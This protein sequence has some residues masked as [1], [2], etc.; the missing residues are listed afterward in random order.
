MAEF[1]LNTELLTNME[2]Q[3]CL[4]R[5][6]STS[7]YLVKS[8]K[9]EQQYV[10]KH[11]S[12]PEHQKQVDALIFSGAAA[13]EQAAQL[14][15]QQ[16]VSDY[17][18]E[19]EQMEALASSP[20]LRCFRSYEIK[21]K[22]NA[23]GF[24]VFLLAE[25][26]QTLDGYLKENA[27]TQTGA[28]NLAMDLCTALTELRGAGL[29]HRDVKP[30]NIYL[31]NQGH[32]MLGDLGLANVQDLK[33][34]SIPES[35]LSS[36]SA[37]ELFDLMA[38]VN[39][40]IDIYAVGMILYRIYNSNHAP[41]EDEKTTAKAADKLRVMGQELPPPMF[42]DYEMAEIIRKACAHK[43]EDRYQDPEEM[44]QALMNYMLRNQV[45]DAPIAPPIV[46]EDPDLELLMEAEA[47]VEPVQFADTAEM[48]E[49][50]ILNMSPD[51]D[52]LND[53]IESVHRDLERDYASNYP[54]NDEI[55]DNPFTAPVRK[56]HSVSRWLP[57]VL[58][59]L[60][61]AAIAAGAYW[62]FFVR[63]D[64]ITINSMKTGEQ[65][66]DSITVTV[67]TDST[68]PF[69]V[70]CTDA[71]GTVQRQTYTGKDVVFT[72]LASGAQYTISVEG[73]NEEILNG[74]TSLTASTKTTTNIVSFTVNNITVSMA[75]LSFVVNGTEPE[76]WI[77]SYGPATG[78][79]STK[80]FS[81]HSV[82]LTGLQP[83]TEY[84][85]QLVDPSD[86]HL[87]G[88]TAVSFRTLPSV[89]IR[90]IKAVIEDSTATITMTHTGS[91]LTEWIV[92]TTGTDGYQDVQEIVGDT[93]IL[94]NLRA[95]ETY[96]IIISSDNMVKSVQTSITPNALNIKTLDA[97]LD[98]N[99]DLQVEWGCEAASDQINWLVSLTVNG[100]ALQGVLYQTNETRMTISDLL[101]GCTYSIEIQEATG[102]ALGGIN[103]ATVTTAEAGTFESYGF[104][105]GYVT[106]W[107]CP[108][109]ANWTLANLSKTKDTFKVGEKIAFACESM[110]KLKDSDDTTTILILVRDSDGRIVDYYSGEETWNNMW[111]KDKY[112][113][114]LKAPEAAG[115]YTVEFYFNGMRVPTMSPV[116]FTIE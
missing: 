52:M 40:T 37:P 22:E 115:E 116:D 19:L 75:E 59:L 94:G 4:S 61:V 109:K 96:T 70:I 99:G 50:F 13:D 2:I 34:T 67:A 108:E 69:D 68:L 90:D 55:E 79:P 6:G 12:V 18:Q 111:T 53:L 33:Y 26:R 3:Q 21:P 24:D 46:A 47:P 11:I 113:G 62:Y 64:T 23:V 77:L 36:F 85:L 106:T 105:K 102:K 65:A 84:Q 35:M 8:T 107:Q 31:G 83:D 39:T 17:Q 28:V 41:L 112:V 56:R 25:E 114:E 103:T 14:Y 58:V 91:S 93:I 44:K 38:D 42:A 32:F 74:A 9:S 1:N 72:G 81:G 48:D 76:Q 29:I 27:L 45:G 54:D 98:D 20:N 30:S 60:L 86:M 15:Y 80:V 89:E 92:T 43:P 78:S 57:T 95:G 5:R 97:W 82:T 7:V 49:T 73:H 101:P 110:S 88:E 51:N 10:L 63:K 16:V 66:V 104:T 100:S 87:T 71:Y